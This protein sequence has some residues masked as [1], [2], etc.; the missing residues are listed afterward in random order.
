VT[1]ILKIDPIE[2]DVVARVFDFDMH[3]HFTSSLL[4]KRSFRSTI[5]IGVKNSSVKSQTL[6]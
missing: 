4:D 1:T 2:A 3:P 6:E 5:F